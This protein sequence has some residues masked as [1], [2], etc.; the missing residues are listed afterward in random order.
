M[1]F[2]SDKN[3]HPGPANDATGG[4]DTSSKQLL[5]HLCFEL[6]PL[7]ICVFQ[8]SLLLWI[9]QQHTRPLHSDEDYFAACSREHVRLH[10]SEQRKKEERTKKEA[11]KR[12][13]AVLSLSPLTLS[14]SLTISL[15]LMEM[16]HI[17]SRWAQKSV[18][19]S[20]LLCSFTRS[21]LC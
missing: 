18:C 16:G 3:I 19:T 12:V 1:C 11:V 4:T 13:L 20:H 8:L 14:L 10:N 17:S 2:S 7:W 21:L 5:Q 15:C 9:I 6:I